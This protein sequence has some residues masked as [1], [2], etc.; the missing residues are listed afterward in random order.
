MLW[1]ALRRWSDV[2]MTLIP[3]LIAGVVTLEIC[4]AIGLKLNFANIIALP[5]LVGVEVAFK[6]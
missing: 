4:V 2:L 6:I 1:I 5:L 3:L